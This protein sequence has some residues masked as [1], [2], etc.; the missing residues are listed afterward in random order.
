MAG[1]VEPPAPDAQLGPGLGDRIALVGLG[2]R[3]VKAGS[4]AATSGRFGKR[5]RSIRIALV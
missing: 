4:N 3:A 2:D 5:S 1:A